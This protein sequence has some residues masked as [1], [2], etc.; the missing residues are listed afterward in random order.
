[1]GSRDLGQ[2]ELFSVQFYEDIP[3]VLA[4]GGS[5]GEVAIWDTEECPEVSSHFA[6][7]LDP[8]APKQP[9]P[10]ADDGDSG[11]EDMSDEEVVT[12]KKSKK[13]KKEK[14]AKKAK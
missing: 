5:Q 14:K 9:E 4:A 7:N 8:N 3:W 12:A 13:E 10:V 2:G 1:M 11:F 6:A